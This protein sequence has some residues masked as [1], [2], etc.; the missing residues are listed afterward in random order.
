MGLIAVLSN[1]GSFERG[2]WR[3]DCDW[4]TCFSEL[5]REGIFGFLG[6]LKVGGGVIVIFG[7]VMIEVLLKR[8]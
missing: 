8:S 5:K 6:V 4:D 1:W 7:L 3:F 2:E